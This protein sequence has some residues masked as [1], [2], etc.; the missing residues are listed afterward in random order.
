M[1][2]SIHAVEAEVEA[3][4]WWFAGR[5]RLFADLIGRCSVPLDARV[6]DIGT[7]TGTNLR[8]LRDLGFVDRRGLDASDE[9][10]RWCAA[11]GLGTVEK[12]DILNLPYGD[13]GFQLVLATDVLEHVE[14]DLRAVAEIRRVLA[15]G[16]TAIISVPA[17]ESLWG[18]QDEAAQH[19][20]RYRRRA[21]LEVL[22]RGGLDCFD[23]FHF[24]YLLFGPI[25][26][27]RQV[28][29]IFRVALQS[30]NQVHSPMLNRLLTPVFAFDVATART[31]RPPFG[32]SIVAVATRSDEPRRPG[33]RP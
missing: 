14:D 10:I 13:A 29:R 7:G 12:G 11:K 1:E 9:A 18:L 17:F 2:P 24:N 32:V 19:K 16:G 27:A 33:P 15:P 4:H 5:R 3:T 21:L 8:L 23:C 20:R 31:V 25:W 28:I 30:E 6:L 22:R 26:C